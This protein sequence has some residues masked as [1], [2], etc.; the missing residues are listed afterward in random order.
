[1]R[2][3]GSF[4][5]EGCTASSFVTEAGDTNVDLGFR[6]V[7]EAR[8]QFNRGEFWRNHFV[9]AADRRGNLPE[10]SSRAVGFRLGRDGT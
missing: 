8:M 3:R 10:S 6:L 2:V 9:T 1:M 4:Y 7:H 5:M